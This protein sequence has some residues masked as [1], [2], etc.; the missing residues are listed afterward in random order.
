M[1]SGQDEG[2]KDAF[3]YQREAAFSRVI[4]L[5]D[6]HITSATPSMVL[7]LQEKSPDLLRANAAIEAW[8]LF[9]NGIQHLKSGAPEGG[10]GSMPE[11]L[12]RTSLRASSLAAALG[13]SRPQFEPIYF[14]IN[15]TTGAEAALFLC[16]RLVDGAEADFPKS[17][18]LI[19]QKILAEKP[20]IDALKEQMALS[21]D[22]LADAYEQVCG[23]IRGELVKLSL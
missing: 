9:L 16:R 11:A 13:I 3:H 8:S 6:G 23:E 14:T 4:S 18:H 5:L 19:Q 10:P 15:Y 12:S 21:F 22:V 7:H 17:R 20:S 1:P 2:R